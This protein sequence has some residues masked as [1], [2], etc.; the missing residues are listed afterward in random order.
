MKQTISFDAALW[1]LKKV[2]NKYSY[3]IKHYSLG[4]V[5]LLI[6]FIDSFFIFS[7]DSFSYVILSTISL[8]YLGL[9]YGQYKAMKQKEARGEVLFFS[10][11]K[12]ERMA[13]L[14]GFLVFS[15]LA[16]FYTSVFLTFLFGLIAMHKL[17]KYLFYTPSISFFADG[18]YLIIIKGFHRKQIDFTYPT[19]LRFAY[20]LISFENSINGKVKWKDINLDKAR[21]ESLKYFLAE[22]FENVH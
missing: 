3:L 5:L 19:K 8:L 11:K 4:T 12:N 14:Y 17:V 22:N 7:N 15:L 13:Y 16:Y 10:N 20:N 18:F 6:G 2:N 21:I 1:D 9:Q